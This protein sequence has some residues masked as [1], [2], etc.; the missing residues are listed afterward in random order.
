G[1]VVELSCDAHSWMAGWLYVLAHPYHAV[2]ADDGS[3]TIGDVPPGKYKLKAWHPV[4][5]IQEQS[6]EV[7]ASGQTKV[8]FTFKA[9]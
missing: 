6:I 8:N 9:N 1:Q 4:L 7:S 2:V 5:N 3:F